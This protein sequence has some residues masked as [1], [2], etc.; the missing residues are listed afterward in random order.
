MSKRRVD[1]TYRY[2]LT[3]YLRGLYSRG[4][5]HI[6]LCGLNPSTADE[7]TDDPT[8]RRGVAFA[9]RENATR[10][11]MV[12][13]YGARATD[14]KRLR[15]FHDAIGPEND[16]TIVRAAKAADTIIAAWGK[17]RNKTGVKRAADVLKLLTAIADVYRLGR[18]T[19]EGHPR[20]PLYLANDK[21]RTPLVLHAKATLDQGTG[22]PNDESDGLR[23][24]T[25]SRET[26]Q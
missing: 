26:R 19:K 23:N 18:A 9:E 6:V 11:T 24:A 1:A 25:G 8:S 17:P 20:H 2:V 3:R 16:E 21:R 14:P 15:H 5:K 13:L 12:N 10:L 7:E 22:N 4:E